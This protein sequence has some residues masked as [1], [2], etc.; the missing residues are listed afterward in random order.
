VTYSLVR[1]GGT[2]EG[3][4]VLPARARCRLR[5]RLPAGEHLSRVLV[6]STTVAADRAGTVDLGDRHGT[7]AVRATV[8]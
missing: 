3:T 8:L 4:L 6:G 5:L 1:H 7:V 2:I